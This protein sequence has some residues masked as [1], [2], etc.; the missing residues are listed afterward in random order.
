MK[1]MTL[2]KINFVEFIDC[3]SFLVKFKLRCNEVRT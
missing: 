2:P 3:S 1:I